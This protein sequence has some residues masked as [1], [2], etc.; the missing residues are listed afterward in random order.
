MNVGFVML[1]GIDQ[2]GKSLFPMPHKHLGR[3]SPS[4]TN[5]QHLQCFLCCLAG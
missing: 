4:S 3:G 5:P 1:Q 2:F